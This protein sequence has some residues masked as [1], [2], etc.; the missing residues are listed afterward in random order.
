MQMGNKNI[1]Y[2]ATLSKML[3]WAKMGN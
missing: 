1:L 3:F 2:M